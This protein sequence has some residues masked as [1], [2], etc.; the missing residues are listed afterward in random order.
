MPFLLGGSEK[1]KDPSVTKEMGEA[2]W[3]KEGNGTFCH[4]ARPEN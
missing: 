2:P 3:A 4:I 1:L